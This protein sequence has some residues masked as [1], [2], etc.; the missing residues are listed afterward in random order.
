[1]DGT[2][3]LP[4]DW[5]TKAKVVR[6]IARKVLGVS[7]KQRKEDKKTWWWDDD[8]QESIRKKRVAKKRWDMQTDEDSKQKYK[9]MRREA[10]IEVAKAY[11]ELYEGLDTK[12]GE[13]VV[14]R[15][16]RQRHHAG[17]DI[18]QVRMM[19]DNGGNVLT[20]EESAVRR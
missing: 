13:Q 14:Y 9:E 3:E 10:K 17:E 12:E 11:D 15:L 7:A 20:D 6:D 4:D 5:A 16:A 2:K 19:K 18:Q 8:V 1:M